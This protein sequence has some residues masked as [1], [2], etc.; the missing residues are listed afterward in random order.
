MEAGGKVFLEEKDS[1]TTVLVASA[2]FLK[3]HRELARKFA[4]AHTE[5]TEWIQ[6]NPQEAQRLVAE[7]LKVETTR[8]M[9]ADLLSRSWQRLSFTSDISS[10]ALEKFVAAAR[11]VGFLK[12]QVELSRLVEIPR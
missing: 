6:R 4:A 10:E 8:A 5:L 12:E 3:E 1:I 11:S 7:Q 9:P 2:A